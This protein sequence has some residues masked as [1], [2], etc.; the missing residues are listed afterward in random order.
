MPRL[1]RP[2]WSRLFSSKPVSWIA[3]SLAVVLLVA[4]CIFNILGTVLPQPAIYRP[5]GSLALGIF[6]TGVSLYQP[7]GQTQFYSFSP[8]DDFVMTESGQR[9]TLARL[10]ELNA[11]LSLPQLYTRQLYQRLTAIKTWL[12]RGPLISEYQTPTNHIRYQFHITDQQIQ[13]NRALTTSQKLKTQALTLKVGPDDLV[14]DLQG[15]VYQPAASEWLLWL[16]A[17]HGTSFHLVPELLVA[18]RSAQAIPITSPDIYV[19]SLDQNL[20][21]KLTRQTHQTL[22]IDPVYHLLEITQPV[23][24]ATQPLTM[25]ST[26]TVFS[27][28]TKP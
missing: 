11:P 16:S 14:Y 13:I 12:G 2:H 10:N 24:S 21:F 26:L 9:Q 5:L 6:E 7:G 23:S 28:G 25:E 3:S 8:L 18:S 17:Q 20:S 19:T 4:V 15:N 27:S 22:Q 1:K